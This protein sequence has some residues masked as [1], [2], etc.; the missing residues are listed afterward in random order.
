MQGDHNFSVAPIDIM[1]LFIPMVLL[2]N[3]SIHENGFFSILLNI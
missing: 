3:M 1:Y 2:S